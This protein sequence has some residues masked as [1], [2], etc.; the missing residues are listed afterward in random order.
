MPSPTFIKEEKILRCH[1][2]FH[3]FAQM[4]RVRGSGMVARWVCP[5]CLSKGEYKERCCKCDANKYGLFK[6]KEG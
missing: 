1:H 4:Q 2:C 5:E 3:V 6:I